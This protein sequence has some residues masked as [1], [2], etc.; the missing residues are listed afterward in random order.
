M[1]QLSAFFP[2]ASQL[3]GP[4]ILA[5]D[6]DSGALI[7]FHLWES[8]ARAFAKWAAPTSAPSYKG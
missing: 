2:I 3:H 1:D 7:S 4:M 8:A 6:Q 5:A